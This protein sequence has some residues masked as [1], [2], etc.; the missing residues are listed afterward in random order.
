MR[1]SLSIEMI[2]QAI[3]SG[4]LKVRWIQHTGMFTP[5]NRTRLTSRWTDRK[6][7]PQKARIS[8]SPGNVYVPIREKGRFSRYPDLFA[9]IRSRSHVTTKYGFLKEI[10]E[11]PLLESIIQLLIK[12]LARLEFDLILE[13]E[14]KINLQERLKEAASQLAKAKNELKQEAAVRLAKGLLDSLNRINPL[15]ARGQLGLVRQLLE[16][17]LNQI[18]IIV[19]YTVRQ[20]AALIFE[21]RRVKRLMKKTQESVK[22]ARKFIQNPNLVAHL[23]ILARNLDSIDLKPMKFRKIWAKIFIIK[24]I[25]AVVSQQPPKTAQ[26]H[27][28]RAIKYLDWPYGQ[29]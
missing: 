23:E 5:L 14:E 13:S 6:G 17:R 20:W 7:K 19:P 9:A 21:A 27:L 24:A 4:R 2:E 15:I 22:A 28:A 11:I 18:G 8:V 25:Q 26:A 10:G 1:K 3:N 29:F 16:E 12:V